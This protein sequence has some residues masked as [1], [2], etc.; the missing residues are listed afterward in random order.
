MKLKEM[1]SMLP[2]GDYF[3]SG[4]EAIA[5][6]AIAARCNY[7]AGYPITPVNE[8]SERM[9][10]RLAEV[11]GVFMQMEDEIASICSAIGAVWA[12]A[13]AMVAT[14]GPGFSL[15]QEGIGYTLM[16]ETPIVIVDGQRGGPS[17]GSATGVGSG[18]MMQARWGSHGDHQ[19]IALSPW[20]V[21]ESYDLTIRAFNYAERYRNPVIMLTDASLA[22]L[23][24]KVHVDGQVKVFERIKRPGALLFG[25]E[26]DGG[27]HMP[28]IGRGEKILVSGTIHTEA[29]VRKSGDPQ[30][31]SAL[32]SKLRDKIVSHKDEIAQYE[33]YSADEDMDVLVVSYGST[34]RSS[35]FAVHELRQEG[36]KV[37]MLRLITIW[38]FPDTVVNQ[39][40]AKAKKLLVPEMNLGQIAGE[41][42][43]YVRCEVVSF[44]QVT[45]E[46]IY[47]GAI[48]KQLRRLV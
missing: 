15:M 2:A 8:L 25:P 30:V 7:Y 6:G 29:G 13:K 44:P 1:E 4:N 5:E 28:T 45:A 16:T 48:T 22:H 24:E 33:A 11:G 38:P 39:F 19:T 36:K 10:K 47:P 3:L 35:L 14:S 31:V 43:K 27:Y 9:S 23:W 37:G 32:T 34:A 46:I 20:S 18:D 12:G 17:T 21:Q 41:L 42:T 40:A 26:I